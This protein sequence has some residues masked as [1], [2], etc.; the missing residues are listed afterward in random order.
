MLLKLKQRE[1]LRKSKKI[2]RTYHAVIVTLSR[3]PFVFS[4]VT[5]S[6]EKALEFPAARSHQDGNS[7]RGDEDE[8][9]WSG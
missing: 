1:F 3:Y 6:L 7:R 5:I 9:S 8:G 2:A 4:I